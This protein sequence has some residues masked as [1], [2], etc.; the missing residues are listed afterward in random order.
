MQKNVKGKYIMGYII[1]LYELTSS[2]VGDTKGYIERWKPLTA[3][4][5]SNLK[6]MYDVLE[7]HIHSKRFKKGKLK[8]VVR[9]N[10]E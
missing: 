2:E 3:N 4:G 6:N 8:V 5:Y 10:V 7:G 1:E 9:G